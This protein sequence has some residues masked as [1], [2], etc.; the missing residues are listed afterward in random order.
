MLNSKKLNSIVTGLFIKGRKLNIS[1]V[2]V[3]QFY[4]PVPKDIRLNSMHYSIIKIP[5]LKENV[6]KLHLIIHQILIFKTL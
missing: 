1:F 6:K 2:F 3:T 5:N 4:F